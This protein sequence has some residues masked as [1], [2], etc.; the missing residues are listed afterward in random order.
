M[1]VSGKHSQRWRAGEAGSDQQRK[2]AVEELIGGDSN[3]LP[4]SEGVGQYLG[5][6]DRD[7]SLWLNHNCSLR[8]C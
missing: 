7:A 6:I 4:F 1:T 8:V 3:D 5:L 2:H